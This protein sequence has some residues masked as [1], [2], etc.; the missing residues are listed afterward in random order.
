MSRTTVEVN[1]PTDANEDCAL[2]VDMGTTNTRVWLALGERVL[3]QSSIGVGVRN[4]ARDGSATRLRAALREV[5]AEA[6]EAG[7]AQDQSCVPS[8]VVAAGMISSPLGL[9]EVPH[10]RAPAGIHDIATN[11]EQHTFPDIT[12]LPIL[13]IPGVRSDS[14]ENDPYRVGSADVMR[15][16]ETLCT[17]LMARGSLS[18]PS[19]LLN[20]GSHWKAINID[21]EGRIASSRTSL[22]GE[23]IHALQTSTILASAVPHERPASI[24]F[25][26]IEAGI[27][28]EREQ[29]LARALFGVRLL[30]Q[31]GGT[32]ADERLAFLIGAVIAADMDVLIHNRVLFRTAPVILTGGSAIALAWQHALLMESIE[33]VIVPE[34]EMAAAL[35]EGLQFF[36][37]EYR[38]RCANKVVCREK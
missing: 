19:V 34:G 33:A 32:T 36:R 27:R 17:G 20:L 38:Y 26:W 24:D 14:A 5:I 31:R 3:A 11:M 15:G 18:P 7:T 22:S 8:C 10:I 28:E 37:R 2:Y 12:T 6:C 29:G 23:L 21:H 30:E 16:E 35:L 25:R 1:T 4:T 9:V 13:L